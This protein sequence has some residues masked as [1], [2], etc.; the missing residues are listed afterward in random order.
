M[1]RI[2]T[3][4]VPPP[5]TIAS[6]TASIARV[7]GLIVQ[8]TQSIEEIQIFKGVASDV[9]MRTDAPLSD[10]YPGN[11]QDDPVAVVCAPHRLPNPDITLGERIA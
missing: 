9:P 2:D 6:L 7:E 4:C 5:H 1:G 8:D 3:F 11:D 10:A